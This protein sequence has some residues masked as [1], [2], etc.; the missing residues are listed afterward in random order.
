[1]PRILLI[2]DTDLVRTMFREALEGAGFEVQEAVDG[3]DGLTAYRNDGADLVITDIVMPRRGGLSVV[4][5]IRREAPE[6]KIIVVSGG[7]R[8]GKPEFLATAAT[9]PG[10][11]VLRKPVRP[12]DLIQTVRELV[13]D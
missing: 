10:V 13:G 4:K 6:A 5:E 11:R 3:E 2:E 12:T 9:Y 8:D 7:A 1:M